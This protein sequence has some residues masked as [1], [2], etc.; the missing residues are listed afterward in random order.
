MN[1]RESDVIIIGGGIIGSFCAYYLL[2]EGRTVTILNQGLLKESCSYGNCGLISP[3]HA[4]PLNSP[5]LLKK[6]ALWLFQKNSPF[7]IKPQLDIKFIEWLMKFALNSLNETQIDN[8]MKGRSN[9][10]KDSRNLYDELFATHN[11]NCNWAPSGIHFVFNKEE[12]FN[13]HGI[14][15]A[16]LSS[17]G[18]GAEPLIGK[19]LQEKEPALT[20]HAF[21]SW[22]YKIDASLNPG[23]LLLELHHYLIGKGV[24]IK[25]LC[26]V[27]QF[28]ENKGRITEIVTNKGNL[29]ARDV[30]M[31]TGA[32]SPVFNKQLKFKIPIVPGKGYSITMKA[33]SI[34]PSC[35]VIFDE[36][37]V[38]ATPWK[39]GFRLGGTMEFS[40][41][42]ARFKKNR[43]E[44]LK[45]VAAKYLKEPY[46]K[47]NIEEWCGWRPMTSNGLPIIDQ[48][49]IH[50]NLYLACG[51]NMLGLSM[52]PSTGKLIAQ[53]VNGQESH[54]DTNAYTLS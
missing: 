45:N 51:H 43:L 19:E 22:F 21:G 50:K 54:L 2:Q 4:L 5:E 26:K 53:M 3:S 23:K 13:A 32:W 27:T 30:V 11:W 47:D 38:V 46:T 24:E 10:L 33:P 37:K 40:G 8:S 7:Y 35:P 31:A 36:E 14:K 12:S 17:L 20:E 44:T 41:Y 1:N 16:R 52:A 28:K 34:T 9:L 15:D 49:P 29:R 25:E 42:N 6:A 18:L 39:D 48:S